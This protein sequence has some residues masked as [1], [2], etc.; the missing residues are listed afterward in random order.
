MKRYTA[1]EYRVLYDRKLGEDEYADAIRS[2]GVKVYRARSVMAGPVLDLNICAVWNARGEARKAGEAKRKQSAAVMEKHNAKERVRKIGGLINENFGEGDYALYLSFAEIEDVRKAL[3]WF[4]RAC[5]NAH[6]KCGAEFKYLYVIECA[7][8]E[9]KPVRPH[10]HIF[11]DGSLPRE[12][13]EDLWRGK[14]GIANATRLQ[15]DENG[16][17]GF[18]HYVQKAPR[19]VQRVRRWACSRNLKKPEERRSCRLPN[20]KR[21]TKK[22]VLEMV[23]GKRDMKAMLE[24]AYPG[25]RFLGMEIRSSEYASGVYID[26][27]MTRYRRN[28]QKSFERSVNV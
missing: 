4:I 27:R 28:R 16:L 22:L 15:P 18:A 26:V 17:S 1:E 6:K 2:K 11:V 10:I 5:A 13:Y 14:Y 12:F 7:D 21:L 3:R 24:E 25:Y 20:G 19:N 23:S 9:G 8:G